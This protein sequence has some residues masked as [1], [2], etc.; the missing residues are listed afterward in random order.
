VTAEQPLR[1][2]QWSVGNIGRKALRGVIEHPHMTL[3]GLYVSAPE[4]AGRDAG[5][6]CGLPASGIIATNSL[7]DIIALD[8]DCVLYMRQG[9]DYGEVCALLASGKN[10]VTTR[11]E[12]HHP[13]SMDPDIRARIEAA[14]DAG[15]T[16][17]YS[18]GSSPGFI[19]EALILPLISLQRRLDCVTIDEFADVSR[20]DSPEMLFQV[21]GFGAQPGPL[22]EGKL[23]HV[24]DSFIASLRQIGDAI[25]LPF[26]TSTVTGDVAAV[27]EDT[28][29]AAGLLKAGTVAAQRITVTGLHKGKPVLRFRAHWYCATNVDRDWT[30]RETGWHLSVAGDTPMEVAITFP[31]ALEDYTAV[32]PGYTAHRAVNAV[33]AVCAAP[34]GIRNTI[35]LPNVIATF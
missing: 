27:R 29:I 9:C 30:L 16:S 22:D 34:P 31:V 21:M 28:P 23:A 11:S 20:R 25:G 3:V 6:L 10:V 18:T 7:D 2:V 24:H 13:T 19:T 26:D 5:D 1:V 32:M 33:A 17:I 35:D 14:C 4:K 12:F 15:K 8:A